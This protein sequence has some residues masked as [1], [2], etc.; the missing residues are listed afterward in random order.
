ML[1]RLAAGATVLLVL[2]L[3]LLGV[4]PGWADG[5]D[6]EGHAL[7]L[8]GRQ[9]LGPDA[10]ATIAEVLAEFER[11]E[12]ARSAVHVIAYKP[13]AS[14]ALAEIVAGDS[15]EVLVDGPAAPAK[16]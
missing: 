11:G 7:L 4:R 2:V 14:V 9:Q 15:A 3:D 6:A 1:E 10:E 12:P 8:V 5:Q 13:K 16:P